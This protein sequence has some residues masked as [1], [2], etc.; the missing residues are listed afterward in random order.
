MVRRRVIE[1]VSCFSC[2]L[3]VVMMVMEMVTVTV[4]RE[5]VTV[6]VMMAMMEEVVMVL[7]V[8]VLMM[9]MVTVSLKIKWAA[10]NV[11]EMS[12]SKVD[13]SQFWVQTAWVQILGLLFS[14]L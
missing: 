5:M 13:Q 6:M 2:L 8:V 10:D 14:P 12:Q 11:T 4:M 1:M 3:L 7:E 9:M